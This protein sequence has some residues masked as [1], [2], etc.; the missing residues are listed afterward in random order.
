MITTVHT[1]AEA[2]PAPDSMRRTSL[3]AGILYL[4]TFVSIPTLFLYSPVRDNADFVLGAGSDT[5]V[6]WGAFSE[7]VVALAGIGTAVVLFRVAKRQSET[8]ALGFI[9]S[10]VVEGSLL[11][12]GVTSLLS[13]VTLRNDVAGSA[14]ADSASLITTGQAHLATYDWTFLLSGSLMPVFNALCLGYVMYRSGLVPRILPTIGLIGAPLL[15]L[16]D[17]AIFFGVYDRVA[18][19]ALLA[20]LPIA[21]WEFS[22]GVYLTVKG[23]KPAAVAALTSTDR[24]SELSPA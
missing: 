21:A 20:A 13:V 9:A 8:A 11:I 4:I 7:V 10:R 18:P 6:L 14:G 22:L 3:A 23:F 15:L 2:P 1:P 16:S 17:L 19:I 12:V 5:G 24:D